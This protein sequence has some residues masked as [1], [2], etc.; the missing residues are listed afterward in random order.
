MSENYE[1]YGPLAP[2][3]GEWKGDKGVDLAPEPGGEEK[4]PYYETLLFEPIG[5]VSNAEK[6][7]IYAL[8]YHQIAYRKSNDKA[9][10]NQTGYWMW[11][12]TTGTIM[13]SLTIPRGVCLLAGG[14]YEGT[15]TPGE[16]LEL[17][18]S[19][20]LG[21]PDWG[22]TQSP[23]MRD[24]ASTKAFEHSIRVVGDKLRYRESTLLDIYGR[25]FDHTDSNMLTRA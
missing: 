20:R 23:F 5:D 13:E 4:A 6:E 9:F 10:H 18:V 8:R 1:V 22:V 15:Y 24:N 21:D 2:L 17:L 7:C 19:A 16:P 11:S 25:E 12:A 3:I 14:R